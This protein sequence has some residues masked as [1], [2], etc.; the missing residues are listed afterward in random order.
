MEK[1]KL[2]I[3]NQ[4]REPIG[5]AAR[6]EVHRLGLWHETFHCWFVRR[7]DGVDYVYLQIRSSKKKIIQIY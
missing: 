5:V 4:R 1:E 6:E 2:K 3:F 7:E